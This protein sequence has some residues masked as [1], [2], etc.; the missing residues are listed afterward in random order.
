MTQFKQTLIST[1]AVGAFFGLLFIAGSFLAYMDQG[2]AIALGYGP[3]HWTI[4]A[5]DA[6]VLFAASVGFCTLTF[7]VFPRVLQFAFAR[8]AHRQKIIATYSHHR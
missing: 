4:Y 1:G 5:R 6:A 2:R 7:G 3:V 8:L